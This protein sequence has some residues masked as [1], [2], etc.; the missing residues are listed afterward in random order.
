MHPIHAC[1][2]T[3]HLFCTSVWMV[4]HHL[5]NE[6]SSVLFHC[7]YL[8]SLKHSKDR[9]RETLF[10]L[11]VA[12]ALFT[13]IQTWHWLATT[14]PGPGPTSIPLF[15][16]AGWNLW[17]LIIENELISIPG[18]LKI[19]MHLSCQNPK[20]SLNFC[21]NCVY[22]CMI[23]PQLRSLWLTVK[24]WETIRSTLSTAKDL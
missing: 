1:V 22:T 19:T 10:F 12:M 15:L 5:N 17:P 7:K 21:S 8:N 18:H 2:T 6:F 16:L 20:L 13:Q 3:A 14:S 24:V 11:P 4:Y 23:T 9:K